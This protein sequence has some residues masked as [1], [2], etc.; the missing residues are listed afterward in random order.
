QVARHPDRLA[1]KSIG[2]SLTYRQLDERSNQ[3][4]HCILAA[5]QKR[6]EPIAFM[7]DQGASTIVTILAILKAGHI[8]VA[9]EPTLPPSELARI[10]ADCCPSLIVTDAKYHQRARQ[11]LPDSCIHMDA[12][13]PESPTGSVGLSLSP[14]QI[15]YI[16]YTSGSTGVPKGVYDNH[17]NVLHNI[18]RYTNNL[19]IGPRDRL[20]LV[21]SA[22]FSGTV[23]SLFAS[24]LNGA[25]VYPFDLQSQGIAR[26]ADWVADQRL[27]IFHSVPMIFQQIMA[28]PRQFPD[29]RLIRLEG[30]Q[31]HHRH[32]VAFRD[33]FGPDCVLVNG[34]GATETGIVRQYFVTPQTKL[35]GNA[36]PIG[37][38]VEDMEVLLLD[39]NGQPVADGV[40]GEIAIRSRYLAVGYWN[41]TDLTAKAFQDDPAQPDCRIYRS[42]DLGRMLPGNCLLYL[43]R[44]DFRV[45]IRGQRIEIAQIEDRLGSLSTVKQAL[46]TVRE[47]R[48]GCQQ[49]V[50]Y[51]VAETGST[52]PTVTGLRR[53]VRQTLPEIMVPARY[54]FC[55][56]LPMDR[57]AKL[58]RRALPA[59]DNARP[60]LDVP[61][62]RARTER[63]ELLVACFEEVLG[64]GPIGLDDGFFDLGG[65]SLLA[66]ALIL[67]IEEKL[68]TTC[69]TDFLATTST[70]AGLEKLLAADRPNNCAVTLQT[71]GTASPLFCL[72]DYSGH[73]MIY[74]HLARLMAPDRPVI[75]L[76]WGS[77]PNA[78]D[79]NMTVEEMARSYV[80][81]VRRIQPEG[82]YHL[83]GNCFGGVVAFEVAQQ[84]RAAGKEVA[85]LA[86]I[87]TGFPVG[88]VQRFLQK[89]AP[90]RRLRRLARMPWGDRVNYLATRT[91]G[92]V[93]WVAVAMR[94]RRPSYVARVTSP[95]SVEAD[96]QDKPHR[97]GPIDAN[98]LAVARYKPRPYDGAAAIFCL[99]KPRNHLG[100]RRVIK[101]RLEFVQLPFESSADRDAMPHPILHPYVT[102]LALEMRRRLTK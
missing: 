79:P 48:P 99:G 14:D 57:N 32:I 86:L 38:P 51:I 8:Y 59:P 19:H 95:R 46:V 25:C 44:K 33:R 29:L 31:T 39:D 80:A 10:V 5:T 15:A 41:Q 65:D 81:E 62:V 50:A 55:D 45:K 89:L 84:L 64:I 43:G 88:S 70:I 56:E 18:M 101:Q 76:Q 42:G 66:T 47:D 54:V 102:D 73:A 72:H 100:W 91:R 77:L 11:V 30:D 28:T 63:Q 94:R 13:G 22:S 96:R 17:R 97:L 40:E 36:V 83:C 24:L 90:A 35:P 6:G 23:S 61:F 82:A 27:T 98:H 53:A 20:S 9:L 3:L 16:F 7:M 74:R 92:L 69:P 78:G 21:Q 1:V 67:S 12:V 58:L 49:L 68:D 2:Q 37:H 85:L 34:L 26:L 93:R 60:S 75:G 87:D 52:P 4:A 71:Q